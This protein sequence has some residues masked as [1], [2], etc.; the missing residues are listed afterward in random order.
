MMT[1][2]PMDINHAARGKVIN[3]FCLLEQAIEWFIVS[4]F[5]TVPGYKVAIKHILLDRMTFETKRGILKHLLDLKSVKKDG[6]TKTKNNSSPYAKLVD[7]IR[8]LNDIR[9]EFAHYRIMTIE[10]PSNDVKVILL[11][12][13]DFIGVKEYEE[14]E[15]D[16]IIQRIKKSAETI[17]KMETPIDLVLGAFRTTT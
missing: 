5:V 12:S 13:R 1:F 8:R 14:A 17:R 10:P 15:V 3:E 16:S 6:F 4:H 11:N 7:E 9:N 2:D